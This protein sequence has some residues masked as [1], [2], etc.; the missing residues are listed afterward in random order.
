MKF[1]HISTFI[2][3]FAASGAFSV[4][5]TSPDSP[6]HLQATS[7]NEPYKL[8][9]V[10]HILPPVGYSVSVKEGY[11]LVE[12]ARFAAEFA[13]QCYRDP[14]HR[15]YNICFSTSHGHLGYMG[16]SNQVDLKTI[17]KGAL[18][19]W[20]LC[21]G[22]NGNNDRRTGGTVTIRARNGKLEKIFLRSPLPWDH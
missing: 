18:L 13:S 19:I 16:D 1:T 3:S 8:D 11:T 14:N 6:D 10:K 5:V 4:P 20:E 21:A 17:L 7:D 9:C 22:H 15:D 12:Q 2:L